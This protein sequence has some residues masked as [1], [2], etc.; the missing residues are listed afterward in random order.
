MTNRRILFQTITPSMKSER[1]AAGLAPPTTDILT[2]DPR[3]RG[4]TCPIH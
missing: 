3:L 4:C 2:G 1:Y